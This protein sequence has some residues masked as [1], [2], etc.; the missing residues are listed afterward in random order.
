MGL[1]CLAIDCALSREHGALDVQVEPC[2]VGDATMMKVAG[3]VGT[4][5][6]GTK[7]N[8]VHTATDRRTA[9]AHLLAPAPCTALMVAGA[10]QLTG[11][12]DAPSQQHGAG[13]GT[14]SIGD[15]GHLRHAATLTND[16][17]WATFTTKLHARFMDQPKSMQ[18]SA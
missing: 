3:A 17:P 15:C 9:S 16:L 1:S 6:A 5:P 8:E 4:A 7:L 18:P 14:A 2:P 12:T 13:D 11:L 10:L